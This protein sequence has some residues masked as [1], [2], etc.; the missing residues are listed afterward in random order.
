MPQTH[1]H[2]LCF[3]CSIPSTQ[4]TLV[5]AEYEGDTVWICLICLYQMLKSM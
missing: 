4:R 1:D 5:C 2:H 3:S